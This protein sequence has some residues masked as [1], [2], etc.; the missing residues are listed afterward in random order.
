VILLCAIYLLQAGVTYG[1]FLWLPKMIEEMTGLKD[2]KLGLVTGLTLVPAIAG[3]ILISA[4][5]DRTGERKWHVVFCGL[6]AAVGVVLAVLLKH[7]PVL[8]VAS[9]A[10]CQ[11]GQRSVMSVF[12]SIPPVFLGVTAAAAGIALINSIGNVGG[13]FGSDVMGW[14]LQRTGNYEG[15]LLVLAAALIVQAAL[16]LCIRLPKERSSVR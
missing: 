6:L 10:L 5:S 4:H 7:H 2:T 1:I 3:M 8:F 15:G 11:I 9:F 13:Y 12:W 14:L 16:V